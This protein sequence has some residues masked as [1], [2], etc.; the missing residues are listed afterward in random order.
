M[1]LKVTLL[2]FLLL[3]FLVGFGNPF[4]QLLEALRQEDYPKAKHLLTPQNPDVTARDK[5]CH[6]PLHLSNDPEMTGC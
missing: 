5:Y 6:T 3:P 4:Q 2:A 1:S